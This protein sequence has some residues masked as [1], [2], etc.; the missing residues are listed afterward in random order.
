MTLEPAEPSKRSKIVALLSAGLFVATVLLY[1]PS[2]RYDYT[3][4]DDFLY[5]D[6]EIITRG[7][8]LDGARWAFTIG[9]GRHYWH[10]LAWMSHMLDA[11]LFGRSPGAHHIVNAVIHAVAAV[12]CFLVLYAMTA[13]LWAA[14]VTAAL[15]AWHPLHVGSVAWISERKDVLSGVAFFATLGVYTWYARRPGAGR[16]IAVF[17]A[18]AIALS[19]KPMLVTLPCVMLLLDVWPLRR[20]NSWTRFALEKLPLLALSAAVCVASYQIQIYDHSLRSA[21][22]HPI[23]L[24]LANAVV[25]YV[26]YL[27]FTLWPV[28]LS[29]FYP[30]R[31]WST[32]QVTGAALVLIAITAVTLWQR[33]RRPHL[34][35][36]WLWFVG[37]MV[38]AIGIIQS[39]SQ[40]MADRYTYLPLVGVFIMIAWSV[41]WQK[42]AASVVAAVVLAAC[43]AMSLYQL[44]FWRNDLTLFGRAMAVTENNHLAHGYVG[45]A[46]AAQNRD[47]EAMAQYARALE[48]NPN[49]WEVHYN[50]GNLLLRAERTREAIEA[51]RRSVEV[52]PIYPDAWNNL[53]IALAMQKDYAEAERSF[54]K[55]AEL[56]PQRAD[57]AA[58]LARVRAMQKSSG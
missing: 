27:Y 8:T 33:R 38:P 25:S 52:H 44:Q 48:L 39:G 37:M 50:L 40:S 34:L 26:R 58:N 46:L 7:V 19:T 53:G 57:I 35:I 11:Q 4:Y 14:F 3:G 15:F 42:R 36:G 9:E 47:A 30:Y 32:A 55:A 28:K 16:Y 45:K 43:I 13:N 18:T 22:T 51:Y 24:R 5:V 49:Y 2:V 41:P 21:E 54:A 29:I 1:L 20:E 6:K 56:A 23:P 17:I 10:P 12:A 31:A